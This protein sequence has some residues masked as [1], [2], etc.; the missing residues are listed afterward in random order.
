MS[1][2]PPAISINFAT[3]DFRLIR[4]VRS[5]LL[6]VCAVLL[7][8]GGGMI[9]LAGTY[10]E[11][12]AAVEQG[13]RDLVAS[14]EKLHP[15]VA[16]RERVVKNLTAMSAILEAKRFSWT[17]F[18]SAL[19]DVFPSGVALERLDYHPQE[20]SVLLEGKAASPEALSG[21]MIR[22]ERS[23][24]FKN[25]LLKRQSMEKGILSFHVTVIYQGPP[26][27]GAPAGTAQRAD[28]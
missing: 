13:V 5:S 19:E 15:I 9:M 23:P 21:L 6:A 27:P 4:N 20:R 18:L 16:E 25:P 3:I 28:Q 2:G 26:A 7:C 22:L 12:T 17:R 11:K 10:R 14:Q 24:S 8:I 1:K